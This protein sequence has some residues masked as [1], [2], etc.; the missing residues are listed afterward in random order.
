MPLLPAIFY[1][2]VVYIALAGWYIGSFFHTKSRLRRVGLSVQKNNLSNNTQLPAPRIWVHCASVGEFEQVRPILEQLHQQK[3]SI[4]LSFFSPSGYELRKNY[5]LAQQVLYMPFDT[6]YAANQFIRQIQPQLAIFV[7]YEIWYFH[8]RALHSRHIPTFLIA[9]HFRPTQLFFR[10]YGEWYKQWLH[11]FTGIGVQ[12]ATTQQY[13]QQQGIHHTWVAGDPRADAV[14]RIAETPF[15]NDTVADFVQQSPILIAGSTWQADEALLVPFVQQ[16][17]L[18]KGWKVIFAPHQIEKTEILHLKRQFGED[19]ALL[20]EGNAHNKKILIIDNIG[21]LSKLYRY[22]H[23]AYIGGGF[24]AG[25]HNILE[26]AVY[27]VPVFFGPNHT[28][29]REAVELVAQGGAC[30]VHEYNLLP[31]LDWVH[32]EQKRL[33][34]GRIAQHYVYENKGATASIVGKLTPY[35]LSTPREG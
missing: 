16:T 30:V 15:S 22:A 24:G 13:L 29:F 2:L 11:Y 23:I 19:A 26:A 7:K 21:M 34:A 28:K 27:S 8:L 1:C 18:P 33:T 10:W 14:I 35:L 17:L 6:P 25:I 32:D 20:S 31:V 9:A 3:A 12:E 4:I 5:P